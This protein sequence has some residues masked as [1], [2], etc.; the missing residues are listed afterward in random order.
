VDAVQRY[1]YHAYVCPYY[2]M[3]LTNE[4]NIKLYNYEKRDKRQ[5]L[6]ADIELLTFVSCNEIIL[7]I[8]ST[9]QITKV[10]IQEK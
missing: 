10:S 5:R 3:L 6:T 1:G 9:G 2:K 4:V 7:N 8:S